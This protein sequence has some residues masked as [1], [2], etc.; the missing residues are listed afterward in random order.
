MLVFY[1][2]FYLSSYIQP[3]DPQERLWFNKPFNPYPA[4]EE[5]M[6]SI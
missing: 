4:N 5:N 2:E 6:V 1:P 3:G